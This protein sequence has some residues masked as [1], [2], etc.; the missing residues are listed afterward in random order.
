LRSIYASGAVPNVGV[1][2]AESNG[3]AHIQAE[4]HPCELR[5]AIPVEES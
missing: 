5:S 3:G 2:S 1:R 4:E